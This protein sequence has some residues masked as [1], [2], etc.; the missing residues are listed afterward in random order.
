MEAFLGPGMHTISHE[1]R[2]LEVLGLPRKPVEGG[3][4]GARER[5]REP[6]APVITVNYNAALALAMN[7][8]FNQ[9]PI[10][11]ERLHGPAYPTEHCLPLCLWPLNILLTPCHLTISNTLGARGSN[12]HSANRLLDYR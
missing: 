11:R 2:G 4:E 7:G 10:Q 5:E 8:V 6:S 12:D 9:P 3:R 1:H